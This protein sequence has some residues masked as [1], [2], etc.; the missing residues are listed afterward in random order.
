MSGLE[1]LH[2]LKHH[3]PDSV[4]L[5]PEPQVRWPGSTIEYIGRVIDMY[6]LTVDGLTEAMNHLRR[7]AR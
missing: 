6:P 2:L 1:W 4:W 3:F 5:N 7:A